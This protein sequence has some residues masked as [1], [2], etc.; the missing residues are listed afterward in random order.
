MHIKR[1]LLSAIAAISLS[2]ALAFGAN[3]PLISGPVPAADIQAFLNQLITSFNGATG[4]ISASTLTAGIPATTVE[5]TL[6]TYTVAPNLLAAGG[7][8]M[9]VTCWGQF[10]GSAATKTVRLYFGA[11]VV[12]ASAATTSSGGWQ[13]TQVVTRKS[14]TTQGYTG[15]GIA[16]AT[17]APGVGIDGAETLTAAVLVKCTGQSSVSEL[18]AVTANGMVVEALK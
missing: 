10:N 8:S 6:Q 2:G 18:N 15:Q 9:R 7:D 11:S 13:L 16:N 14:A 1:T 4:K 5:T 17:V 3:V 12:T